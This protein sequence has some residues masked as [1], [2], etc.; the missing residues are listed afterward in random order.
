MVTKVMKCLEINLT[1]NMQEN[2]FSFIHMCIQCLGHLSPLPPATRKI[3]NATWI[4]REPAVLSW[5][6]QQSII[7]LSLQPGLPY[8]ISIIGFPLESQHIIFGLDSK[9]YLEGR[10]YEY[11]EYFWNRIMQ[12]DCLCLS[13][14]IFRKAI[15]SKLARHSHAN[16]KIITPDTDLSVC[17][18]F[19][20]LPT[21][22]VKVAFLSRGRVIAYSTTRTGKL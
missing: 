14:Y 4:N 20:H 8:T 3:F 19:I 9:I 10:I 12:R 15:K 2:F 13:E 21:K 22:V 5:E 7:K 6:T 1:R 11:Q 18:L 16:R 17:H